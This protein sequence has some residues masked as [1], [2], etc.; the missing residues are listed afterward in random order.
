MNHYNGANSTFRLF[1]LPDY[2]DRLFVTEVSNLPNGRR[3]RQYGR[4][5]FSRIRR[6]EIGHHHHVAG[7]YLGR[8]PQEAVW[9]EDNRRAAN[10]NQIQ[11]VAGLA[12]MMKPSVGFGGYGQRHHQAV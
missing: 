6:A 4:E 1:H 7:P 3:L 8:Y 9:R 5:F 10:G 11:T 12:P 2:L